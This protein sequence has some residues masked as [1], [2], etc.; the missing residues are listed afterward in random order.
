MLQKVKEVT[1]IAT[2]I[3]LIF[4]LDFVRT[5]LF[6]SISVLAI[7]KTAEEEYSSLVG[8]DVAQKRKLR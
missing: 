7:F 5:S 4:S 1:E 3:L 8:T 6:E 2:E